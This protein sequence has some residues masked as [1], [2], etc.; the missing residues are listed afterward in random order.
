MVFRLASLVLLGPL[1]LMMSACSTIEAAA[2]VE[3][4]PRPVDWVAVQPASP[5]DQTHRLTGRVEPAETLRVAFPLA[6]TLNRLPFREGEQVEAGEVVAAVDDLLMREQVAQ[7]RAAVDDAESVRRDIERSRAREARLVAGAASTQAALDALDA[8]LEGAT[9]RVDGAR[10]AFAQ[11]RQSL[12]DTQRIVPWPARV[13]RRFA[14]VGETV[15]PGQVVME[16]HR[17]DRPAEVR[18]VVPERW[19]DEVLTSGTWSLVRADGAPLAMRPVRQGAWDPGAG[20]FPTWLT[21]DGDTPLR[22]GTTVTVHWQAAREGAETLW[23]VPREALVPVAM[24]RTQVY[25]LGEGPGPVEPVAVEVVSVRAPWA[26]VRGAL[27]D[28]DRLVRRG[29]ALLHP[30]EPVEARSTAPEPWAP[31]REVVP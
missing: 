9:A 8:R 20:G 2:P 4:S 31:T 17:L 15:Q 26:T 24:D 14:E 21:V 28:G 22:P 16:L 3:R 7:A 10:A 25:R 13:A 11:A 1:L 6:G 12:R 30:E 23:Q 5:M 19:V 27:R 18:V 29:A